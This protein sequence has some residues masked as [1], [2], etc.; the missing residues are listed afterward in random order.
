MRSSESFCYFFTSFY[1]ILV[2]ATLISILLHP[3]LGHVNPALTTNFAVANGQASPQ[4]GGGLN[5][6]NF[7]LGNPNQLFGRRR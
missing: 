5:V 4:I 1:L 3:G 7:N 6:G 2:Y